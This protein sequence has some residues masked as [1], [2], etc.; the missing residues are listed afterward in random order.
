MAE[1]QLPRSV[2]V[3]AAIA[4]LAPRLIEA[5]LPPPPPPGGGPFP[6]PPPGFCPP[7]CAGPDF[8]LDFSSM[9]NGPIPPDHFIQQGVAS[10]T[11]FTP[12]PRFPNL[13]NQCTVTDGVLGF[14]TPEDVFEVS[15]TVMNGVQYNGGIQV[16]SYM[17]AEPN[18]SDPLTGI[19]G[20]VDGG[21]STIFAKFGRFVPFV[22]PN[23]YPGTATTFVD[24]TGITSVI[25]A[26]PPQVSLT[27]LSVFCEASPNG[28]DPH[29]TRWKQTQRDSL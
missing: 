13:G 12:D 6:P 5:Q 7:N 27:S 23:A 10:F 28:G 9:P 16:V 14:P 20:F 18:Q 15:I 25:V 22:T 21:K 8:V 2:V 29:F 17:T 1:K 24:V 3:T 26:T 19:E 11:C 4:A